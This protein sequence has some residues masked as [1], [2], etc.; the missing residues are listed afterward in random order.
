MNQDLPL[1]VI[2]LAAG[3]SRRAG[4]QK[5]LREVDGRPL[6]AHILE[7]LAALPWQAVV[8][9]SNLFEIFRDARTAGF[10]TTASPQAE[11]GKSAS[12]LSGMRAL[13]EAGIRPQGY[14]FCVADQPFIKGQTF[15][16]LAADFL[17]DPSE[18]V[19]PLYDGER[20]GNP[21]F[22]PADCH[23]ELCALTGEQGGS[24][25]LRTRPCRGVFVR[26]LQQAK[27]FDRPE[28]FEG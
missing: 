4:F 6:Y 23:D 15:L 9:V 20:R 8:C 26:G 27:D 13:D 22:F 3:F 25:L 19:Y 12:I 1:A 21:M 18:I 10:L 11:E 14:V 2:L 28:D 5:L 16:T 17:S 24:H 7:T